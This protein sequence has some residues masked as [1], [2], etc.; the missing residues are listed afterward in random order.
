M[1][2]ILNNYPNVFQLHK[3]IKENIKFINDYK[4]I[5][6]LSQGK[7]NK[8]IL[9]EKD[10]K[11]YVLKKY[12]KKWLEKKR[13]FYKNT[14]NKVIL[15]SKFDDL[16][17]ELQILIDIN[18][19]Y[20]LSCDGIITDYNK[21]YVLN[22]YMEN[23]SIL[24]FDEFF[25]VL[26]K[27]EMFF[28]P[29]VVIKCIIK[30]ILKSFLYIHKTKNICHRDVKPSNILLN[31]NGRIK[32]CDYG[33]SQYMFNKKIKGTKGTYEFMPP[34]FFSKESCYDGEKVD[35]WSLGICLYA[36]FYRVLPFRA[37]NSLIQLFNDIGKGEIEYHKDRNY[38]L[39]QLTKKKCDCSSNSLTN[40][41]INFLKCILKKNPNERYTSEQALK[42]NWLS[43][44]NYKYIEDYSKEIYKKKNKL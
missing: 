22:E 3:Y 19:E 17:T 15:K 10:N 28:I 40:E 8:I 37:K 33:E 42:N 41:D 20:C 18:N 5:R 35:I 4:I 38:F 24:K 16:K 31:K 44:V 29:I 14:N 1:E 6:T 36:L 26:D 21:I 39:F 7:L 9:C 34:E 13:D 30:N 23:E 25:Y 43:D 27:E 11:L 12:N 32:L 2:E